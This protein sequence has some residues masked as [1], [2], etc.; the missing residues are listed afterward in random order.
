MAFPGTFAREGAQQ[1]YRGRVDPLHGVRI[2]SDKGGF[3]DELMQGL[4]QAGRILHAAMTRQ[5]DMRARRRR[6]RCVY[7]ALGGS[8]RGGTALSFRRLHDEWIGTA[9]W[10]TRLFEFAFRIGTSRG[11]FSILKLQAHLPLIE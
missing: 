6:F 8:R 9:S 4:L 5:H 1:L 7:R 10:L 2:E 11:A 3:A